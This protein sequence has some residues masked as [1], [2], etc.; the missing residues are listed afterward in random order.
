MRRKLGVRLP[1]AKVHEVHHKDGRPATRVITFSQP[2]KPGELM[3]PKR[4]PLITVTREMK[5]VIGKV[6]RNRNDGKG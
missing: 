5:K 3:L 2:K 1:T 4:T 6:E